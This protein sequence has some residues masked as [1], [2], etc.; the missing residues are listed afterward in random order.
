MFY[1]SYVT[2]FCPMSTLTFIKFS[3]FSCCKCNKRKECTSCLVGFRS[4]ELTA[5]YIR[6][7]NRFCCD[8]S[9]AEIIYCGN[10][11]PLLNWEDTCICPF[12]K[13]VILIFLLW[14]LSVLISGLLHSSS[15]YVFILS[16]FH[17][18]IG[19]K[20]WSSATVK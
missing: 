12:K 1:S 19:F 16:S 17:L 2:E 13:N 3:L 11:R 9:L 7:S 10:S 6:F 4:S 8:V 14:Y 18:L 15:Y 5:H 20:S